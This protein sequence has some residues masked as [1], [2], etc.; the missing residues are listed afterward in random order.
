MDSKTVG[1]T[2]EEIQALDINNPADM[3]L[4]W[5]RVGRGLSYRVIRGAYA[6]YGRDMLTRV[7]MD[8]DDAVQEGYLT[9]IHTLRHWKPERGK[10]ST[11]FTVAFRRRMTELCRRNDGA[12]VD[13]LL[14]AASLD[15]PAKEGAPES[16]LSFLV[17]DMDIEA[18][19][20]EREARLELQETVRAALSELPEADQKI[21]TALYRDQQPVMD[22]AA[23]MGLKQSTMSMRLSAARWR[24]AETLLDMGVTPDE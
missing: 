15:E 12:K 16:K 11:L 23:D 24:L 8:E 7:G 21:L 14:D 2:T 20:I 10:F 4:L 6:L 1:M 13:A 5:E 9:M 3:E 18:D 22:M 19:Y 17:D